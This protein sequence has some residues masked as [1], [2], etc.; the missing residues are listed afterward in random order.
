MSSVRVQPELQH[1]R[2]RVTHTHTTSA[3]THHASLCPPSPTDHTQTQSWPP[4]PA[5]LPCEAFRPY[6]PSS[7]VGGEAVDLKARLTSFPI[8]QA[9]QRV[10][11]PTLCASSLETYTKVE[12]HVAA[13]HS[14]QCFRYVAPTASQLLPQRSRCHL[15]P[16]CPQMRTLE[17]EN[18]FSKATQWQSQGVLLPSTP[19]ARIF[20]AELGSHSPGLPVQCHPSCPVTWTGSLCFCFLCFCKTGL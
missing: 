17:P 15:I 19:T 12:A 10:T 2:A 11:Q 8:A 9:G 16:Q 20:S 6:C 13:G 14:P 3:Y 7:G 18:Y 4:V 5:E 1:T